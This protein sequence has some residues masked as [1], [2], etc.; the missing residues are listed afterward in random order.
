MTT[1]SDTNKVS[2]YIE[3]VCQPFVPSERISRVIHAVSSVTFVSSLAGGVISFVATASPLVQYG[4]AAA[5]TLSLGVF[6]LTKWRLH[7]KEEE[8]L[9][10]L[11]ELMMTFPPPPMRGEI[12]PFSRRIWWEGLVDRELHKKDPS[13]EAKFKERLREFVS[14]IPEAN[15]ETRFE[16]DN[17]YFIAALSA[18][19]SVH[20]EKVLELVEKGKAAYQV[21]VAEAIFNEIDQGIGLDPVLFSCLSH[22]PP[23][24]WAK[25]LQMSQYRPKFLLE[26]LWK[27]FPEKVNDYLQLQESR[28]L[29]PL[30]R[31]TSDFEYLSIFLKA[32]E[33]IPWK[34]W[35]LLCFI[36][37]SVYESHA[38]RIKEWPNCFEAIRSYNS[39]SAS[40]QMALKVKFFKLREAKE[41]AAIWA[42]IPPSDGIERRV[43]LQ[44]AYAFHLTESQ[45]IALKVSIEKGQFL[46]GSFLAKLTQAFLSESTSTQDA[47]K[48]VLAFTQE[49][50]AAVQARSSSAEFRTQPRDVTLRIG[51][52]KY[53]AHRALL[54]Q[55][56]LFAQ[57]LEGEG[58]IST[59]PGSE[60][61]AKLHLKWLYCKLTFRDIVRPEMQDLLLQTEYLSPKMEA[62][63]PAF[64]SL[65]VWDLLE[66]NGY[67]SI[68]DDQNFYPLLQ[69]A[70]AIFRGLKQGKAELIEMF[71]RLN[72]N[73]NILVEAWARSSGYQDLECFQEALLQNPTEATVN[74]LEKLAEAYKSEESELGCLLGPADFEKKV[75]ERFEQGDPDY[76]LQVMT[77]TFKGV[78]SGNEE[79]RKMLLKRLPLFKK[80]DAEVIAEAWMDTGDFGSNNSLTEPLIRA[81]FPY[82]A[83]ELLWELDKLTETDKKYGT[84]VTRLELEPFFRVDAALLLQYPRSILLRH[85]QHVPG[86]QVGKVLEQLQPH[87]IRQVAKKDLRVTGIPLGKVLSALEDFSVIESLL[88]QVSAYSLFQIL[89]A[90]EQA[91]W[92][93]GS[94][95][96]RC[97]ELRAD[98]SQN[99][100]HSKAA[101]LNT[102]LAEKNWE[103]I[104]ELLSSVSKDERMILLQLVCTRLFAEGCSISEGMELLQSRLAVDPWPRCRE[105]LQ[106]YDLLSSDQKEVLNKKRSFGRDWKAILDLIN[107]SLG[108]ER[109]FL[110]HSAFASLFTESWLSVSLKSDSVQA[111]AQGKLV[112][113]HPIAD[114]LNLF[115]EEPNFPTEAREKIVAFIQDAT[116]VGSPHLDLRGQYNSKQFSDVTLHLG[117]EQIFAHRALLNL[118]P[119]YH[120]F[121]HGKD[122]FI[123][124]GSE[125]LAKLYVKALYNQL[126]FSELLD[127]EVQ[128]HFREIVTYNSHWTQKDDGLRCTHF[129]K[130]LVGDKWSCDFKLEGTGVH[131][132]MLASSPSAF[133]R[134]L[135]QNGMKE[136]REGS[137]PISTIPSGP[138]YDVLNFLYAGESPVWE[139]EFK[140]AV[141]FLNFDFESKLPSPH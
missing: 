61:L 12:F 66:R 8:R 78:I 35:G 123:P 9:K 65:K 44:A 20:G 70:T 36:D 32:F 51:E 62:T 131:R 14:R 135:F 141:N 89:D 48:R 37:A 139:K 127:P 77:A 110:I 68:S 5:A 102:F 94:L 72:V 88:R 101:T 4:C 79:R 49:V 126:T 133:F 121:P 33:P 103:A 42:C 71:P 19:E 40:E 124:N 106:G 38:E 120:R 83:V 17:P 137:C 118:S 55:S 21:K 59:P 50:E 140:E 100:E 56:P 108:G 136:T 16:R 24:L 104:R 73:A 92:K 99:F 97:F 1:V 138:L 31:E 39:L 84:P 91:P 7:G 90:F 58:I 29:I 28:F 93:L 75:L 52:K 82:R 111:I 114:L 81:L 10:S 86:E 80:A 27:K 45:L 22:V 30:L 85:F 34:M 6:G 64:G 76:Q 57:L 128:K 87:E 134:V 18:F 69:V 15:R 132:F 26:T 41:W 130:K 119:Y 3:D 129:F 11:H 13:L 107:S 113:G 116:K 54:K 43:L 47:R 53:S 96:C 105:L 125:K 2:R 115:L 117:Q 74:F 122:I 63:D 46:K 112:K 98:G 109:Q 67:W 23:A 95:L 25:A 60:K